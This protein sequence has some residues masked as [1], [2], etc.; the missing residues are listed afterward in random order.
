VSEQ[1]APYLAQKAAR[2]RLSDIARA[3][4]QQKAQHK[5]RDN[6]QDA[7]PRNSRKSKK[8]I[9]PLQLAVEPGGVQGV[10]QLAAASVTWRNTQVARSWVDK[11]SRL[12]R[13]S[14]A[15]GIIAPSL[16]Q[17]EN[18]QQLKKSNSVP[19]IIE[20]DGTRGQIG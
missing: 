4:G 15:M 12:E 16:P 6:I 8:S 5:R 11:D 14:M 13:L 10:A 19:R 2:L 9:P 17:T 20:V 1:F 18:L 3:Y 7:D